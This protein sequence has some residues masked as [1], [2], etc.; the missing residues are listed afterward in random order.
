MAKSKTPKLSDA[1]LVAAFMTDLQ[2]PLKNVVE[3]LRD[4]IKQS[5]SQLKERIKWNAPSYYTTVDLLTFNLKSN[6]TI[7]LILHNVACTK[8]KSELLEGDYADR[9]II[10]FKDAEEVD[11]ARKEL[12]R[13]IN[14][15]VLL[16]G[17]A[18]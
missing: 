6:N 7:L 8:I 3:L 16:T 4:V 11:T 5:N 13:I 14:E 15:Y 18:N 10:Y 17:I 9:R 12:E 1:E 2:H